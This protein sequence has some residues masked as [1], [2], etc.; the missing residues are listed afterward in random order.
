MRSLLITILKSCTT[1][2]LFFVFAEAGLRATYT[3]RNA[4]VRRIPLPYSVG[5]DYGPT[6]PWLDR[7]LILVPD[8]RLIWR[9]TPNVRRT[10]VDIFGPAPNEASRV[11]LLRRFNPAL[12]AE[13]RDRPTWTISLNSQGFRSGEFAAANAGTLRVACIG[14]SWT[15]GMNVD[16]DRTYPNRLREDL[17]AAGGA[18]NVDV[19]N[20]G[21]LGYSS[22]QGLELL[23]A[24]V[25]DRHP[26]VVAIGFGMN[27]SEV[28][29]YRDRDMVSTSQPP[30]RTRL[31]EDAEE[32]EFY[33]L[34]KYLALTLRFHPKSID[35]YLREQSKDRGSGSVD[36]SAIE[37]WT[38][39]SP[40]DY[41]SNLRKMIAVSQSQGGAVIL[42]D[43]ELW[44]ESPYRRLLKTVAADT[45]VPLVDSLQLV[46]DARATME[47][48]V[49]SRLGLAH[50]TAARATASTQAAAPT[51]VIFRIARGQYAVPHAISI[52]GTDPQLGDASPNTVLMHDDGTGGDERAG[53]GVWSLET[54][55]APGTH[56]SY[57]YT[58]GG[59]PGR[60]EGLDVPHIRRV[61]IPASRDGAPVFLPVETF[62][63][64][65]MQADDWH[66]NAAG[67]ELIARGVADVIRKTVRLKP[68]SAA[69]DP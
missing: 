6:P 40:R 26:D 30:I 55:F 34:L 16:Q 69:A 54:R 25:L 47:R 67:Y 28:A 36:Y 11:A 5:D 1:T 31:R 61:V 52:A 49:E 39:V 59:T 48:E 43:N 24:R 2:I 38:R 12:P 58:N 64:V 27:D 20:F 51:R 62:G 68:D 4:M 42:L 44:A 33:K 41:E 50:S 29:G 35:V 45:N 66:T 14:D 19:E 56:L 63:E 10:Y 46:A 65:Y 57:V 18:S 60:W 7:L 21:V 15:F 3:V 9:N 22:F 13:F 8:D 37:P 17:R 32:L 53:D 23:K